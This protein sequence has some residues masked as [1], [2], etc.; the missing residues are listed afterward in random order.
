GSQPLHPLTPVAL[1]PDFETLPSPAPVLTPWQATLDDARGPA[2][3]GPPAIDTPAFLEQAS[4]YV[5]SGIPVV[6]EGALPAEW[7]FAPAR[8]LY[9]ALVARLRPLFSAAWGIPPALC[10]DYCISSTAQGPDWAA[11]FSLRRGTWRPP[12]RVRQWGAGDEFTPF[13]PGMLAPG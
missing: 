13:E 2:E 1:G 8:W 12:Q 11:C 7:F 9:G 6:L 5:L 10:R 4:E 3:I